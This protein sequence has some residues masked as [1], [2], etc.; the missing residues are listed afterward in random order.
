MNEVKLEN[1][2]PHSINL[3]VEGK[4]PVVYPS[5]GV[6]RVSETREVIGYINNVPVETVKYGQVVGLPSP[7]DGIY[8]IVSALVMTAATD[9]HDLIA[10]AN[11]VRDAEQ[12]VVGCRNWSA[13]ANFK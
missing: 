2:T 11:L 7:Q 10:P 4:E 6:A 12:K 8:Y 5:M 13:T 1:F 3:M 9:R